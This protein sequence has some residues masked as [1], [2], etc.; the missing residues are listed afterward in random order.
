[1]GRRSDHTPEQLQDLVLSAARSILAEEGLR[2]L[3]ARR[4]AAR[5]GYSPGT[6]YNVYENLDDIILRSNAAT[7]DALYERLT[8]IGHHERPEDTLLAMAS[9]YIEFTY[10]ERRLWG[11]LFEHRLPDDMAWP[12]WYAERVDR[13]FGLLEEALAPLFEANQ[14]TEKRRARTSEVRASSATSSLPSPG[15]SRTP[16][17]F[18]AC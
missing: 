11:V 9:A 17:V 10:E 3:T 1:M 2:G 13:L 12:D 7:L 14:E 4:L 6:L 5:I 18:P 15:R 16:R 8:E